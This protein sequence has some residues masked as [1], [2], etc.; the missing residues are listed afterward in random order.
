MSGLSVI[1]QLYHLRDLDAEA[2][3]SDDSD[4]PFEFLIRHCRLVLAETYGQNVRLPVTLTG[5]C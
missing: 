5:G 3:D 4:A 1:C 2:T